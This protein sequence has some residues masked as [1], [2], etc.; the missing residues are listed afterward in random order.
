MLFAAK[1][2]YHLRSQQDTVPVGSSHPSTS[3]SENG[4]CQWI[5]L[6][7]RQ[8][9]LA[10]RA[11]HRHCICDGAGAEVDDCDNFLRILQEEQE[12]E[13]DFKK[14]RRKEE[15][16]E[17]GERRKV[18]GEKKKLGTNAQNLQDGGRKGG[19]GR[20][21]RNGEISEREKKPACPTAADLREQ[22][23]GEPATTRNLR[24]AQIRAAKL[25]Q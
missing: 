23:S 22:D 4:A 2:R 17:E 15:K 24:S 6:I 18:E 11:P 21:G 10:R 12:E 19:R 20:A 8:R 7:D 14:K 25:V 5:R 1:V 13:E 16:K 3:A 9:S